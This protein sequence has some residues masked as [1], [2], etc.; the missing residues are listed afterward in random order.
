MTKNDLHV[1]VEPFEVQ[2]NIIEATIGTETYSTELTTGTC[3]KQHEGIKQI[4]ISHTDLPIVVEPAKEQNKRGLPMMAE[5]RSQNIKYITLSGGRGE[6]RG[7][8]IMCHTLPDGG[9]GLG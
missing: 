4:L 1:V 3:Q 2:N 7:S 8:L 9:G 6:G 5:C